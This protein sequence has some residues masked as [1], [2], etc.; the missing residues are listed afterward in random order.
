VCGDALEQLVKHFANFHTIFTNFAGLPKS[1]LYIALH[2][3][4]HYFAGNY[5]LSLP[6]GSLIVLTKAIRPN[7]HAQRENGGE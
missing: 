4:G 3:H 2:T 5:W 6:V 1:K 7:A